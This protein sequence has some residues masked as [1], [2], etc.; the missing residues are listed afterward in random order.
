MLQ[1]RSRSKLCFET[2]IDWVSSLKDGEAFVRAERIP[3]S[4]VLD[5]PLVTIAGMYPVV[6]SEV[7]IRLQDFGAGEAYTVLLGRTAEGSAAA[8]ARI[9]HGILSSSRPESVPWSCVGRQL[10]GESWAQ[11]TFPV[12]RSE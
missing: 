4:D 6:N 1:V 9:K 12:R 7:R 3:D 11:I 10:R 2:W 8:V 5:S